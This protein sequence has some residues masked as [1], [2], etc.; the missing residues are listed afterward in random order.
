MVK[1]LIK[2]LIFSFFSKKAD[3]IIANSKIFKKQLEKEF[4]INV[5]TIYNPL[6][7]NEIK[8]LSKRLRFNFF[9][10]DKIN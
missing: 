8:N 7:I 2:R 1:N 3:H 5:S 6:N 9:D 4:N 10:K